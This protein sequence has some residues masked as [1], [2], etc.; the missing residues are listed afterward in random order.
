MRK[1]VHLLISGKVQGVFFRAF[2]KERADFYG[3]KGWVK[4]LRDGKVEAVGEGEEE[5]L[6]EWIKDLWKG[7][8]LA[9][10]KEVKEEWSSE[11]ENFTDFEIRYF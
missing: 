2:T 9:H 5:L 10:V 4:N 11:L 7:P 6:K 1:R 8:E 3:I